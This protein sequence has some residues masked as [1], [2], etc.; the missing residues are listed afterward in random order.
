[1]RPGSV[2]IDLAAE[3]GGNCE[4]T[5][6]N[7][8]FTDEESGVT[9][10]GITNF[11]SLM[12]DQSST[13]YANNIKNLLMELGGGNDL[14]VDRSN[15]IVGPATVIADGQ[16]VFNVP[17]SSLAPPVAQSPQAS[18][19]AASKSV[20]H[21]I[22]VGSPTNYNVSEKK[23][24]SEKDSLLGNSKPSSYQSDAA[25]SIDIES[26]DCKNCK[27][28][29]REWLILAFNICLLTGLFV[30]LGVYTPKVFHMELLV[31]VLSVVVGQ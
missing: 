21:P 1:M 10:V 22:N 18:P 6:P 8:T 2:I 28:S 19:P 7:E 5:R 31:F 4:L 9:I 13:L 3:N 27:S 30:L 12:A 25:V 20:Q 23:E 29:Y 16:I 15:D 14:K 11:P 17:N 24:A 26:D